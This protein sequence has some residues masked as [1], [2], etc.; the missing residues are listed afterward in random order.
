[1]HPILSIVAL[2]AGNLLLG[3]IGMILAVPIAACIQIAVVSVLPKLAIEVEIPSPET[4]TLP[5]NDSNPDITAAP[6]NEPEVDNMKAAVAAA[7][8]MVE[9]KAASDEL[10]AGKIVAAGTDKGS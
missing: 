10:D 2:L 8:E 5:A 4:S 1:L 6:D 7:V 9:V 3:I